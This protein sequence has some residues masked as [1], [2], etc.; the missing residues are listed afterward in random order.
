M[1]L[2]KRIAKTVLSSPWGSDMYRNKNLYKFMVKKVLEWSDA[3]SAPKIQFREDIKRLFHVPESKFVDLGFGADMIDVIIKNSDLTRE[4]AKEKIGLAEKYLITCGYNGMKP[5][6]HSEII[7]ALVQV[8]EQLPENLHLLLPMTYGATDNYLQEIEN[9][10]NNYHFQYTIFD[11]FLSDEELLNIRKATD[12]FIHAQPSDAFSASIQEYLLCEAI[13]VN[14]HWTRY[15]D[16]EKFG[17]PY[18][19][20]YSF[21]ELPACI[22]K[23]YRQEEKVEIS[24]EL[25]GFIQKKGWLHL[26]EEWSKVYEDF[27]G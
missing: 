19:L 22:L 6:H 11:K 18:Y 14:G 1:P 26:A 25:K 9:Q 27:A 24:P 5:Q 10:L 2:Y 4:R 15:P 17:M 8:R 7:H 20:Y 12:M 3:V 13:I 23:A 16:F 21:D